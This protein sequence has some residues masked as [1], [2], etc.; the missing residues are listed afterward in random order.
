MSHFVLGLD[1]GTNSV[2]CLVVRVE[3]GEEVA[4]SVAT[5]EHGEEGILLDPNDPNLA[6]QH[7]KDYETGTEKTVKEALSKAASF[8]G[9]SPDKIIGIGV[10]T[11]GST[12]LPVDEQGVPLA[13]QNQFADNLNAMAWLWKDHTSFEE[14]AAITEKA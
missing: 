12:P 10:D 3:D 2:R 7:P 1:F 9:F 11:T 5:Y 14:A 6:R 8:D 13:Y 4:A